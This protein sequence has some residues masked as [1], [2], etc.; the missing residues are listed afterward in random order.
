MGKGSRGELVSKWKDI[1]P[2]RSWSWGQRCLQWSNQDLPRGDS[3]T[4]HPHTRGKIGIYAG[5]WTCHQ[6]LWSGHSTWEKKHN[7]VRQCYHHSISSGLNLAMKPLQEILFE[8]INYQMA[9]ALQVCWLNHMDAGQSVKTNMSGSH[10]LVTVRY[11]G[12]SCLQV[13]ELPTTNR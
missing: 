8:S 10:H 3:G 2:G 1:H 5:E 7:K 11:H 12:D 9:T 4:P 6:P 13:G